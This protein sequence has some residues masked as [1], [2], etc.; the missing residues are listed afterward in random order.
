M[1]KVASWPRCEEIAETSTE[2]KQAEPSRV[3]SLLTQ[4][5][6]EELFTKFSPWTKLQQV[7]TN[8][9][10][11]SS[12]YQGALSPTGLNEATLF[13]VKH[14][15]NDNFRKEKTDLTKKGLSAKSS[16]LSLHP[17]LDGKQCL[18]VGGRL[19]NSEMSFDQ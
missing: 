1:W 13:C 17:F 16:L 19:Q 14:A 4:P 8:C 15:Q 18:R 11:K 7:S 3:R 2:E 10:H 9:H 5:S 12:Q 6:D